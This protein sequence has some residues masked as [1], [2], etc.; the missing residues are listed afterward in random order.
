MPARPVRAPR[1][2]TQTVRRARR[3]SKPGSPAGMS[4]LAPPLSERNE[5]ALERCDRHLSE[6]MQ[7][8]RVAQTGVQVLFGFLLTVPFTA[9]FGALSS[10][11]R[12]VYLATLGMA[13][14]AAIL[15]IAPSAQHRILFRCG[16]KHHIVRLANRYAIAGLACVA[17]A[18][19]GA[20][21]LVADVIAHSAAAGAIGAVAAGGAAWCWYVQPL[22]RR[23]SLHRR[24]R[25]ATR[26][27]VRAGRPTAAR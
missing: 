15:L 12:L 22:R 5:T 19:A 11:Q 3:S 25:D 7:E 13:G 6:L 23:Q 4:S 26:G 18:M 27:P 24:S 17:L 1:R 16:D 10:G 2:Y 14:A 9:H 20:L 21:A 8:V